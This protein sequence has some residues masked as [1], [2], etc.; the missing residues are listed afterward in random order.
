[1][2]IEICGIKSTIL[3]T[4]IDGVSLETPQILV[5]SLKNDFNL[6]PQ[7]L[8]P[9]SVTDKQAYH[10]ERLIDNKL[11][12]YITGFYDYCYGGCNKNRDQNCVNTCN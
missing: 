8:K 11:D 3:N 5:S 12:T 1:M 2:N 6:Q 7:R 10:S 9:Q 4:N